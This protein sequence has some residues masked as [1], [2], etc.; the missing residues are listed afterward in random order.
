MINS[1]LK[2]VNQ[3]NEIKGI[4]IL[5]NNEENKEYFNGEIKL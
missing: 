2:T 3:L 5:I 1:I 4:K